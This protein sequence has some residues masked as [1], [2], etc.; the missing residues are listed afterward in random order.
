MPPL[1]RLALLAALTVSS[2]LT[3]AER[4]VHLIAGPPSHGPGQHEHNAGVLLLQKCLAGV[5]GL[6][7]EVTLGQWP[8]D[9]ATLATAD[10]IVLFMDGGARHLALQGD[11]LAA[12]GAAMR[13]GAGLGLLHFAVEPTLEKGQTEF[14]D[15][16]GA[17]FEIN[18]SVN[19][20]WDARFTRLPDHPVTRGVQPFTIKDEWYFHLRFAPGQPGVTPL[21]TAV[22]DAS[23]VSRPDGAHS[24]NPA[25]RAAV[26]RGEPQTVAWV[27]ERPDGGR[28]FGFTG[29]HYHANWGQSDFRRL[30]LN[31]IVWLAHVDVPAGGVA[32]Q[33]T[34]AELAAN[35]DPKPAAKKAQKAK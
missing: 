22:P 18:W 2:A 5:P 25:M 26:A 28:G 31:A 7:V 27:R 10:A 6:R 16:V 34:A 17:A 29:A 14:I 30:V 33:P 12:L 13:R 4:R 35:L 11:H 19:P 8:S 15:W 3:G 1:L 21:L 9:P 20:H 32:S 24:G 23:T